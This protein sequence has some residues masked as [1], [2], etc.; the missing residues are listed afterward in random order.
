MPA[1]LIVG[2]VRKIIRNL[3]RRYFTMVNT[4][5]DDIFFDTLEITFTGIGSLIINIRSERILVLFLSLFFMLASMFCCGDI[6]KQIATAVFTPAIN[7][8]ESLNKSKLDIL[9]PFGRIAPSTEELLRQTYFS[10]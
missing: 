10:Y 6:F 9:V 3:S 7:S 5:N 2:T 8:L 4:K 1:I